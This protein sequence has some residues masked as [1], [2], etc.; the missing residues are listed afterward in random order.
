MDV[1]DVEEEDTIRRLCSEVSDEL[2]ALTER[3]VQQIR[4]ELP[5]YSAVPLAE[6]GNYIRKQLSAMLCA[7][8][9]NET[10]TV[11]DTDRNRE[12]GRRRAM[13]GLP[14]SNVI[15]TYHIASRELWNT[16]VE[17]STKPTHE[18][19][20][21]GGKLWDL[22]HAAT[23]AVAV[24]HSEATRSEQAIRAGVRYRFF[25]TLHS[26]TDIGQNN[27]RELALSLG[28]D[29]Q[30]S[31]QALSVVGDEWS[32]AQVEHLQRTLDS[33]HVV[34]QCSRHGTRVIAMCQ[35]EPVE[36]IIRAIMRDHPRT[37]LGIGM[38]REGLVGAAQSITDAERALQL[39]TAP[40]A[41]VSFTEEWLVATLASHQDE[42]LPLLH[43]GASVA[44][45][46]PHL[47]DAVRAFARSGFSVSAA[48]RDIH[49]HANSVTYRLDRWQHLTGWDPR[50]LDGLMKSVVSLELFHR[51]ALDQY[52]TPNTRRVSSAH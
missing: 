19:L 11:E 13:Q 6:Q 15:E 20:Q 5:A 40:G 38:L 18:L 21:A 17:R 46:H 26:T 16:M 47:M 4:S 42:L 49:L 3:A 50:T 14:L 25:E 45:E 48:A 10:I 51:Q 8:A 52:L 27:A 37:S 43:A 28:F 7:V 22:V 41:T 9:E 23:S 29:P 32:E 31:F 39:A 1:P 2:E 44:E 33:I 12:L 34:A 30:K 35:G 36:D 24:G